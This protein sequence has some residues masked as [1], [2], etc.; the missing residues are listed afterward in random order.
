MNEVSLNSRSSDQGIPCPIQE[1]EV[2]NC[3][4]KSPPLYHMLSHKISVHILSLEINFNITPHQR[5]S[6]AVHS[7]RNFSFLPCYLHTLSIS[8]SMI[9]SLKYHVIT[10]AIYEGPHCV[11]FSFSNCF[12]ILRSQESQ[13]LFSNTLNQ[14]CPSECKT[15]IHTHTKHYR[16]DCLARHNIESRVKCKNKG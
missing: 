14:C 12:P 4:N 2:H 5:F 16:M 6:H 3:V 13:F 8:F 11:F 9:W 15:R 10:G 7:K 1:L